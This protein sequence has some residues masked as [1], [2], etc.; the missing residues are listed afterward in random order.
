MLFPPLFFL[1][2]FCCLNLSQAL[3]TQ[4]SLLLYNPPKGLITLRTLI[5]STQMHRDTMNLQIIWST[6]LI[7]IL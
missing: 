5:L 1:L 3:E 4:R 7:Q 2:S 6:M